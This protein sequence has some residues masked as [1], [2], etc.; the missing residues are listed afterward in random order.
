MLFNKKSTEARV[1]QVL[2]D[3]KCF[4]WQPQF[5]NWYEI[6][7]DKEWWAFCFPQLAE[8]DNDIAWSKIPP[9]MLSYIKAMPEFNQNVW[10]K[11]TG[12]GK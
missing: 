12:R 10:D 5:A 6:K 11:L 8:V 3:I 2:A 9:E 1:E 7:G 4:N